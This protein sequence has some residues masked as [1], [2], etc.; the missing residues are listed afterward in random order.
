MHQ[1]CW[2]FFLPFSL[3]G[4]Y[5]LTSPLLPSKLTLSSDTLLLSHTS[6]LFFSEQRIWD[7]AATFK[8][9]ILLS[10]NSTKQRDFWLM[11][12]TFSE[13]H[14]CLLLFEYVCIY[15]ICSFCPNTYLLLPW[16]NSG[17]WNFPMLWQQW[18]NKTSPLVIWADSSRD[19]L[20]T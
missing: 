9:C 7:L 1:V 6:I 11:G 3:Y 16:M 2:F 15:Y 12:P 8:L 19:M 17:N 10:R 18:K 20:L 5:N 14:V 4:V 13:N